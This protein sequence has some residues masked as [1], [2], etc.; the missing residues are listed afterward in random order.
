MRLPYPLPLPLTCGQ[1]ARQAH[2][3]HRQEGVKESAFSWHETGPATPPPALSCK[4]VNKAALAHL[5]AACCEK[6][7]SLAGPSRT[8]QRFGG[9]DRRCATHLDAA[10]FAVLLN[11]PIPASTPAPNGLPCRP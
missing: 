2:R 3:Q 11:G 4:E 10:L 8:L 5:F 1:T 6:S 7:Q 9:Q